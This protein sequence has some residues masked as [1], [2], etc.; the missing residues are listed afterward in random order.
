MRDK[1][2]FE[3]LGRELLRLLDVCLTLKSMI[4]TTVIGYTQSY[5]FQRKALRKE[6]KTLQLFNGSNTEKVHG[7]HGPCSS[8]QL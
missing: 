1:P 3:P 6:N 8:F 2:G 5:A 7:T 4:S